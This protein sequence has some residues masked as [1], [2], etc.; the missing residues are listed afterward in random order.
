MLCA[1]AVGCVSPRPFFYFLFFFGCRH[2]IVF[3]SHHHA[4]FPTTADNTCLD[5]Y[6]VVEDHEEASPDIGLVHRNWWG[7]RIGTLPACVPVPVCAC[8]CVCRVCVFV[9]RVCVAC[10][11]TIAHKRD[12]NHPS[13]PPHTPL[14]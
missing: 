12:H 2:L 1:M 6:V 10:I 4:L 7:F 13:P 3:C 11:P 9:C 5:Q 8:V 14:S